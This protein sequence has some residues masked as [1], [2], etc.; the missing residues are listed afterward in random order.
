[1]QLEFEPVSQQGHVSLDYCVSPCLFSAVSPQGQS[2][3]YILHIIC[4]RLQILT[5]L[6]LFNN[7][8]EIDVIIILITVHIIKHLRVKCAFYNYCIN[9]HNIRR[10]VLYHLSPPLIPPAPT[11]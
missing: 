4:Y 3:P 9:F 11:L 6:S 7:I 5:P 10:K 2:Q 8:I 1:M